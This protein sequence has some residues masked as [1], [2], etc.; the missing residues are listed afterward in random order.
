MFIHLSIKAMVS[1][2]TP[3]IHELLSTIEFRP[4]RIVWKVWES[5]KNESTTGTKITN[6]KMLRK[7]TP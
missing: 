7:N 4:K 3:T 2:R 5:R 1:L 6:R